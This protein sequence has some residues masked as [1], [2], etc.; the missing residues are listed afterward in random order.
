M[1]YVTFTNISVFF[2]ISPEWYCQNHQTPI[3]CYVTEDFRSTFMFINVDY[4]FPGTESAL[5]SRGVR[6]IESGIPI[7][8]EDNSKL[9]Q[10]G[11][12]E[13]IV[14]YFGMS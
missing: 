8:K 6:G 5:L 3:D 7:K 4:F 14:S 12:G 9:F 13:I 11:L 2:L 10:Y 1:F